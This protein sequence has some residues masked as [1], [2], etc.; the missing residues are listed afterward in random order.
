MQLWWS[1]LSSWKR[2]A[3]VGTGVPFERYCRLAH[4][5]HNTEPWI[6]LKVAL[7]LALQFMYICFVA[8]ALEAPVE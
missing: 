4:L 5:P 1:K 3:Q 7:P 8:R 6:Y 2:I